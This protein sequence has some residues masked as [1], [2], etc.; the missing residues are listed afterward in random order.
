MK[1][2]AV[3]GAV[4]K[5][6]LE[7]FGVVGQVHERE[8]GTVAW[9]EVFRLHLDPH[10]EYGGLNGLAAALLPFCGGHFFDE[11]DFHDVFRLPALDVGL[12]V[13]VV[14]LLILV[15][16]ADYVDGGQRMRRCILRGTGFAFEGDGAVGFGSVFA[17]DVGFGTCL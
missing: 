16:Q 13:G 2:A 9:G 6:K 14:A 5:Q 3:F 11:L 15:S 8:S 10:I 7:D 4:A 1:T 12:V 17:G